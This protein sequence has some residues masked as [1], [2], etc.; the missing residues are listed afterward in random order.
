[1]NIELEKLPL[2]RSKIMDIYR[3]IRGICENHNLR[4]CAAFGT[5]LGA[6]RHKGFIP[7][8]DDLDLFMPRPDF[9]KFMRI[10]VHELPKHY[11]PVWI[12]NMHDFPLNF[13]KIQDSRKDVVESISKEIG[14]SL[15]QGIYVDIFPLDGMKPPSHLRRVWS[16]IMRVR[17]ALLEGDEPKTLSAKFGRVLAYL[18]WILPG[19]HTRK[20]FVEYCLRQSKANDYEDSEYIGYYEL[21]RCGF[22]K[23]ESFRKEWF[24]SFKEVPFEGE[25]IP[26]PIKVEEMLAVRYGDYL[27]LPPEDQRVCKHGNDPEVPW[28]FGVPVNYMK[29]F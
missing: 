6:V 24:E 25:L 3:V 18:T 10:A 28:R 4:Y 16:I 9:E 27:V 7:W 22:A 21:A 14:H 26:V 15:T 20:G 19:P 17:K 1:M 12:D 2:L 23:H 13:G 5:A 8:D 29:S 11:L